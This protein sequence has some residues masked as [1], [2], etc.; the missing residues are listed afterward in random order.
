VP[1]K[2]GAAL[3]N[4]PSPKAFA[5][6]IQQNPNLVDSIYDFRNFI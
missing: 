5:D 2:V 3:S 4:R 6:I 1:F